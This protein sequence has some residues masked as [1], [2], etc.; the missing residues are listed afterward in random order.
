MNIGSPSAD[1]LCVSSSPPYVTVMV[2]S[3]SLVTVTEPL[4]YGIQFT[5]SGRSLSE[6]ATLH[7]TMDEDGISDDD[8][9]DSDDSEDSGSC[10]EDSEDDDDDGSA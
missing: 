5:S 8:D 4:S 3:P 6:T 10:S 1:S 2:S 7:A 9:S